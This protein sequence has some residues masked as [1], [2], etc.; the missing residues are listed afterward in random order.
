MLRGL[1]GNFSSSL[2]VNFFFHIVD[3]HEQK[4]DIQKKKKSACFSVK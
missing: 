2:A 1:S 3:N 4:H